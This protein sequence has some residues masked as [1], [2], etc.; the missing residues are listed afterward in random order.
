MDFE[1][2]YS[3]NEENDTSLNTI[4][5]QKAESLMNKVVKT[6]VRRNIA[7]RLCFYS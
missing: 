2:D 3:N 1:Y 4:G 5:L 6:Q 7:K